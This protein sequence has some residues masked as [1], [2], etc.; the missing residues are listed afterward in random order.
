LYVACE[1]TNDGRGAI[2]IKKAIPQGAALF[3]YSR[4]YGGIL[5]GQAELVR[6]PQANTGPFQVPGTLADDQVLF[7]SDMLPTAWHGCATLPSVKAVVWR[8]TE[9]G[10]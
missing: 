1:T 8:S 7:L 6:V 9:Q 10:R 3:G 2:L 4:L 5:G